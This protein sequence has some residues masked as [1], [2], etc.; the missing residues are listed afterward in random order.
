MPRYVHTSTLE[1]YFD[2]HRLS[3]FA[4]R[5]EIRG[6]PYLITGLKIGSSCSIFRMWLL[7]AIPSNTPS[8]P[9]APGQ[10]QPRKP[11]F[12]IIGGVF[13]I[14][15]RDGLYWQFRDWVADWHEALFFHGGGVAVEMVDRHVLDL[16][17]QGHSCNIA[18]IPGPKIAV[19]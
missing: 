10:R 4:E 6:L 14:L 13:V 9:A 2:G 12:S 8:G 7:P 18:Y 15:R 16:R 1:A 19:A 11:S 5:R 3:Q 17:R